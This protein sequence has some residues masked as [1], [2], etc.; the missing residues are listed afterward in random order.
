MAYGGEGGMMWTYKSHGHI[1][2]N[3]DRTR[4]RDIIVRSDSVALHM[5]QYPHNIFERMCVHV[6]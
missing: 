1:G 2:C 5:E 6:V 4:E 3:A